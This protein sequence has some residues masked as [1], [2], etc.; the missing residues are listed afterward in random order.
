MA[1]GFIKDVDSDDMAQEISSVVEQRIVGLV[2][3][4]LDKEN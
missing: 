2:G 1:A 4:S 3:E